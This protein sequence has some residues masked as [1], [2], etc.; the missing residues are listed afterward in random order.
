MVFLVMMVVVVVV[1]VVGVS[2]EETT[3]SKGVGV[4]VPA[5]ECAAFLAG[6]GVSRR[7]RFC[8]DGM[9]VARGVTDDEPTACGEDRDDLV[10]RLGGVVAVDTDPAA[11]N[12]AAWETSAAAAAN[13][14]EALVTRRAM[15]TIVCMFTVCRLPFCVVVNSD[16][17]MYRV[18]LEASPDAVRY[19][20]CCVLCLFVPIR[21]GEVAQRRA[22]VVLM[23]G[24]S[25][26]N[27]VLKPKP[28][29][30]RYVLLYYHH[31]CTVPARK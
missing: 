1:V 3:A 19:M 25:R 12:A 24:R 16:C 18:V 28:A 22:T 23:D 2:W 13:A 8:G 26:M 15:I 10:L 14:R 29:C 17:V 20:G 4:F 6:L 7:F 27:P 31:L 11:E 30:L 5:T 9:I 21:F